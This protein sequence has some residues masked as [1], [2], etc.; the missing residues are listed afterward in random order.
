MTILVKLLADH[1]AATGDGAQTAHAHQHQPP[2]LLAGLVSCFVSV[3]YILFPAPDPAAPIPCC[4]CTC[5]A[6]SS[7]FSASISA[8]TSAPRPA[9]HLAPKLL[10]TE[11][12]PYLCCMCS[13]LTDSLAPVASSPHLTSCCLGLMHLV[14]HLGPH[15]VLRPD[16]QLHG[17]AFKFQQSC[18]SRMFQNLS[19]MSRCSSD[20]Q[21][22]LAS[23]CNCGLMFARV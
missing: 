6:L 3:L 4:T 16:W 18:Q 20:F 15:F 21:T 22:T 23:S 17:Q 9:I 8:S 13:P 1:L 19:G 12:A 7:P 14:L 11:F 2:L 5:R 10:P